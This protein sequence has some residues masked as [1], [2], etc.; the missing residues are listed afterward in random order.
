MNRLYIGVMSGTSLDGVDVALCKIGDDGF[1]F[2]CANAYSFDKS[3]KNEVL[4]LIDSAVRLSDIGKIDVML[5][6][7]FA[8][9][10]NL[11]INQNSLNPAQIHAIGLH[12]Q[13]VWHEP[14]STHPF[15]MQLG[16]P[17]SVAELTGISVVGD[18]RQ[19]D[20]VCGGQGA[21]FA[22]AFHNYIFAKEPQ[23]AVVN[24]GGMANITILGEKLSGYDTGCGNVLLDY[25]VQKHLF[26]S[27]D[28]SGTWAASGKVI[29]KLL[30]SFLNEPFFAKEAPKST[31]RELF[32]AA[33]LEEKLRDFQDE[34][35]EN[36]QATLTELTAKSIALEV[37]RHSSKRVIICGGGAKNGF[38][39]KR[40]EALLPETK[41]LT[42]DECGV[43]SEFME[44]MAF[45]YLAYK[46]VHNEPV[47]LS[48][49]T[50]A[51]KDLIL[52]GIYA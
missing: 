44:A 46:R 33:W 50:G 18:F 9:C 45:A 31:G 13:T 16:D 38:L 15:S 51:T 47:A 8:K 43:D 20:V 22:P 28:K 29:N 10:I 7:F 42:S 30:E 12:G 25:W 32:N 36:V 5:G 2:I 4:H 14:S 21:P 23:T 37:M 35:P 3:L 1:E 19:R 26:F 52:G 24:I 49:V 11:F 39:L 48:S 41:V 40:L 6:R 34:K 17:N 27:Y